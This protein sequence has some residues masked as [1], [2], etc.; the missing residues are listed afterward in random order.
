VKANANG[1]LTMSKVKN[2]KWGLGEHLHTIAYRLLF[3]FRVPV[4]RKGIN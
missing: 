3:S 1:F 4:S 2:C